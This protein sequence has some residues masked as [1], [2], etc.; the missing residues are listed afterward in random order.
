MSSAAHAQSSQPEL[1]AMLKRVMPNTFKLSG[2][3]KRLATPKGDET[4]ACDKELINM[5]FASG[6]S[7]FIATMK[8]KG[9]IA[10]RGRDSAAKGNVARIAVNTILLTGKSFAPATE[11]KA[12]GSCTYTNPNKGPVRVECSADTIEGKYELSY[13]SDGVWP[14]K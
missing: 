11:L 10:F 6:N 5:A 12:T 13:I 7:S 14:P 8:K 9:S 3:C 2:T 1:D 4:T